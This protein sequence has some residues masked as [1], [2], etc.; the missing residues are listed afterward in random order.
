VI[1]VKY[2]GNAMAADAKE[3]PLFEDPLFKEVAA[4]HKAGEQIVLVHGGGPE[5]DA[6]LAER[7]VVT[8]RI[9]GQRVTDAATLAVTETVLCGTINTRIVRA[10]QSLGVSAAG[11]S[12][13][14]S[15]TLVARR[16]RGSNGENL[17]YVGEITR[18]E[19]GPIEALLASHFLPVIAP[20]AVEENFANA[21]NV[22]ADAS[23]G[24]IAAAL[25][26]RAL[27]LATDVPRVLRDPDDPSSGI[28]LLT[29]DQAAAFARSGACRSSMKPK[30]SAAARA[31]SNGTKSYICATHANTIQAALAGDATTVIRLL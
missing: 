2:G 23:A 21:L 10:L 3:D 27:I 24:A 7:G 11:I 5:I 22:N 28:D 8:E 15:R 16:L 14:S 6:A 26:A 1:V 18:V 25:Y 19:T 20:L 4:L 13:H 30:L 17:G 29:P 9:E 12:G 31:A